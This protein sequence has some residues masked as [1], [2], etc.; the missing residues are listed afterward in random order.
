MPSRDRNPRVFVIELCFRVTTLVLISSIMELNETV[1]IFC[2]FFS[3]NL[4]I[5][6]FALYKV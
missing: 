2:F 3:H 4:K 5:I 1:R 6:H